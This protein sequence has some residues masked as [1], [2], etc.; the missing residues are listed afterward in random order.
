MNPNNFIEKFN[1]GYK[2]P[3]ERMISSKNFNLHLRIAQ[4]VRVDYEVMTADLAYLEGL[5]FEKN[6]PI[7]SAYVG[8]R[9]F[10]GAMPSIGDWVIVGFGLSHLSHPHIIQYYQTGYADGIRNNIIGPPESL[11]DVEDPVRFKMQKLYE[12]EVYG[13]SK[14]GSEF[15]LDEN[16]YISNST[17]NEISLRAADQ[18][19]NLN[20][21][22]TYLN[23]AGL[24]VMSGL[25]HRNELLSDPNF[26]NAN[27]SFPTY[28]TSEG[29]PY[30]TPN[31]SSP[32]NKD[33]PYGKQTL[34]DDNDGFVEHRIEVKE[35]TSPLMPVTNSNSGVD[36]DSFYKVRADGETDKPLVIQVLGT[37]V[38]NDP[39]GGKETYGKILKPKIFPN[40]T[41]LRGQLTEEACLADE[42]INETITTA[43][44][45]ALKFPNTDT[46]FYVNKQGKAFYN[47]G[48]SSSADPLGGGESVEINLKG[49]AKVYM[50]TNED[51]LR[52]F[53][54]GTGG[55]VKTDWGFDNERSLSWDATFGRG[56][57]WH[58]KGNASDN[59]ALNMFIEGTVNKLITSSRLTDVRADDIIRVGGKLEERI[60]GNR[61]TNI[62]NNRNT[63]IGGSSNDVVIGHYDQVMSAGKSLTIN[64][65]DYAAGSSVAD[66]TKILVGNSEFEIQTVGDRTEKLS[67]GS[68]KTEILTGSK[69]TKITAGSYKVDVT[70]GSIKIKTKLGAVDI[71]SSGGVVTVD[72]GIKTAIKSKAIVEVD[73]PQVLIGL[74]GN[75]VGGVVTGGPTGNHRDYITGL[76]LVGSFSVLASSV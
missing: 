26:N 69:E 32:I 41:A 44:A 38:G 56:V 65:P 45:Y 53:T 71:K 75:V 14:Y 58:I 37:L 3:S 15:L 40:T 59:T 54:F 68:H 11:K 39:V 6:V 66:S 34:D 18:S 28:L 42:G 74:K 72:G 31:F 7:S 19:I 49:A 76:P 63:N 62:I 9:G 52:S 61:V 22:N 55:G 50:G 21:L 13:A 25:A 5:G 30:Y 70:T 20:A 27:V 10:M 35:M 64:G 16:I 46:A 48:A 67:V 4:I 33:F 8:Q 36:V 2:D 57:F 43:A 51:K 17:L 29:I 24:R 60:T 23:N 73:A 47:Y 1:P 12:G